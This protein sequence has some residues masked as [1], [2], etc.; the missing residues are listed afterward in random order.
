MPRPGSIVA[1]DENNHNQQVIYR[2]GLW[3]LSQQTQTTIDR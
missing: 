3:G 2:D 1:V